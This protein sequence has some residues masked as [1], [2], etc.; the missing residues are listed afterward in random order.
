MPSDFF[1]RSVG[2]KIVIREFYEQEIEDRQK[3]REEY[4]NSLK[5]GI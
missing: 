1:N 4:E 5:G 3:E 2:E